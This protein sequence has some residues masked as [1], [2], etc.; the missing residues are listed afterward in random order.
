VF[1]LLAAVLALAGCGRKTTEVVITDTVPRAAAAETAEPVRSAAEPEK[2]DPEADA[3]ESA[4]E[5]YVVNRNSRVFHRPD[6]GSVGKI[7]EKNRMDTE[8]TRE[9]LIRQGYDPCG[10]C[11]P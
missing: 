7:A 10:I 9:D 4:V 2:P 11:K 3:G 8:T 5:A 1:L 6:C